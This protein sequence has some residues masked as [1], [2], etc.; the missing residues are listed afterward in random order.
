MIIQGP[1]LP[2]S[3]D[4][5]CVVNSDDLMKA[6]IT[7]GK[8]WVSFAS[9]ATHIFSFVDQTWQQGPFLTNGRFFHT[10]GILKDGNDYIVVVAG[11]LYDYHSMLNSVELYNFGAGVSWYAGPE[12]INPR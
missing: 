4:G 11:G 10:C 12:M 6:L 2:N 7:G 9:N 3:L 8:T 5:H 1:D